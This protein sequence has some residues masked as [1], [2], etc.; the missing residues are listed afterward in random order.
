MFLT[1]KDFSRLIREMKRYVN[2]AGGMRKPEKDSSCKCLTK[3]RLVCK[4]LRQQGRVRLKPNCGKGQ[5]AK[6]LF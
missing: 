1:L 5:R 3:M 4:C 6:N 2:E